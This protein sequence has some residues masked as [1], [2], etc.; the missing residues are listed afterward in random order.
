MTH[1]GK[2]ELIDYRIAPSEAQEHWQDFL[3]RLEARGLRRTPGEEKTLRL[4]VSDGD[5]GLEAA[6]LMVYPGVPHQLCVFHKLQAIAGH[7]RQRD[8][9]TAIM[10]EAAA[11]YRELRSVPQALKRLQQWRRRWL[12]VEPEAVRCFCGDFERTLVYLSLPEGDRA[13]AKTNNPV[14]RF[15][16][17]LNRKIRQ[18]GVLPSYQS[19]DRFTY[20]T[21]HYLKDGGYPN[22]AKHH[23]T[24]NS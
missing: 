8:N 16:R 7:L 10:A 14:E 12:S 23:F 4:L 3:T 20:L 24:H 2:E 15:I 21:W 17:E 5:G 9:R 18:V 1:E 11:I 19:W 6:R 13:R 22:S